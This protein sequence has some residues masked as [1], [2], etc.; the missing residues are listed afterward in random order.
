MSR[1]LV[2][3]LSVHIA[4]SVQSP[5]TGY[6]NKDYIIRSGDLLIECSECRWLRY[7][8]F[9]GQYRYVCHSCSPDCPQF[10]IEEA[11]GIKLIYVQDC[12]KYAEYC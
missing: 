3:N 1:V 9:N 5:I 12:S 10:F 2:D 7:R 4:P 8:N 11:P 6:L